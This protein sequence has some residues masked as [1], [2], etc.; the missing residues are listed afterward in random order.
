MRFTGE[1]GEFLGSI[2]NTERERKRENER[3]DFFL[4]HIMSSTKSRN[5]GLM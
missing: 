3:E 1:L 4:T 5:L 2:P